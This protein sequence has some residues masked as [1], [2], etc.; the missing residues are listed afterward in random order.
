MLKVEL[1][2]R[3]TPAIPMVCCTTEVSNPGGIE[4]RVRKACGLPRVERLRPSIEIETAALH[5]THPERLANE[6]LGDC[7][8][9]RAGAHNTD[10]CFDRVP[11]GQGSRINQHVS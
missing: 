9:G 3:T 4:R 6:V 2:E 8:P 5:Q 1:F 7:N 11:V 10:V